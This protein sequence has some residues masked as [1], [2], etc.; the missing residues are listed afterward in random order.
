MNNFE[1]IQEIGFTQTGKW[2]IEGSI[3]SFDIQEKIN[4]KNSL[5]AFII[6]EEVMY[7]GKTTNWFLNR[8]KGYSKPGPSQN[9]NIRINKNIIEAI[10]KKHRVF[11]YVLPES[12]LLKYGSFSLSITEG[13]EHSIISDINPEWNIQG[14]TKKEKKKV[15]NNTPNT[16]ENSER[17]GDNGFTT[18]EETDEIANRI[19]REKWNKVL[20]LRNKGL[21]NYEI[22]KELQISEF[23]LDNLS[24]EYNNITAN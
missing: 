16:N 21:N 13:L 10:E 1:R 5:Y 22:C 24:Y 14:K 7:V 2:I 20:E 8:M 23:D 19:I 12:N 9:T 15:E 3:I 6:E 18:I 4:S 17:T 11:V